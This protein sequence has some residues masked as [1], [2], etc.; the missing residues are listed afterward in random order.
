MPKEIVIK[1]LGELTLLRHY[2]HALNEIAKAAKP[3]DNLLAICEA[4]AVRAARDVPHGAS[5][6]TYGTWYK[7][8][9][10]DLLEHIPIIYAQN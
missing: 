1:D 10:Q 6:E 9:L 5:K 8:A 3:G 4:Q 2:T 7:Q